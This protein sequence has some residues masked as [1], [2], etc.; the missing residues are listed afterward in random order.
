VAVRHHLDLG[1]T[2]PS[3]LNGLDEE[4]ICVGQAR[5]RRSPVWIVADADL[6]GCA[7]GRRSP[8]SKGSVT[9]ERARC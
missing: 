1:H 9:L 8:V 4:P 3:A 7:L 6:P 5:V 2:K